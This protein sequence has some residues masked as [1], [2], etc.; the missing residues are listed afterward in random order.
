MIASRFLRG[1]LAGAIYP[2]LL[3]A[4]A[5]PAAAADAAVPDTSVAQATAAPASAP[6]TGSVRT[7]GGTPVSGAAVIAAGPAEARTTTL[8][9]GSFT[10]ALPPGSYRITVTKNGY[11]SAAI[12]DVTVGATSGQP[13][14]VTLTQ[15]DLTSLRTIGSVTTTGRGTAVINTG[16]ATS[17]YIPAQAFT[18]LANPQINNVLQRT[19]DVTIQHMGSQ[20]DTTIIVGGAQPYETQVLFDGHPI[21]LGQYGVW[22]SQY[23]PSF[24]IGG[25]ELQSGPGNTTPFANIAVGG[26]VNLLT[27]GYTRAPSAEIT[28]GFDN[29]GSQ[30]TNFLTSG[31]VGDSSTSPASAPRVRTVRISGPIAARSRPR[32]RASTTRRRIPVSFSF[33]VPRVARFTRTVTCSS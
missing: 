3:V 19:P 12:S 20:A 30:N 28:T 23:F 9:D 14:A 26:T 8:A 25:A 11:S 32:I 17:S 2:C 22:A 16:A 7:A 31:S 27:P 6:F 29:Y 18:N 13:F 5:L 33:A 21:A 24:L 15:A 1:L 4:G 10:L